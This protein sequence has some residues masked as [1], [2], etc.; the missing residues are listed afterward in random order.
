[1]RS[2]WLLALTTT[3]LVGLGATFACH[4]EA[5]KTPAAKRAAVAQ[6]YVKPAPAELK[7]RLTPLQFDVTQEDG[8]EPPFKNAYWDNKADGIYVDVVTGEPLFSSRDKFKSGTGWPSFTQP[9]SDKF[10]WTRED[11][12]LFSNRTEVRSTV[13]N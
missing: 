3:S 12:T 11:N 6:T 8:T 1:M 7:K 5:P 13:G 4:A 10:V 2:H 9:I